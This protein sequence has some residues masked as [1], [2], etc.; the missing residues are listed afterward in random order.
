M[1]PQSLLAQDETTEGKEELKD[2]LKA[3]PISSVSSVVN[4]QVRTYEEL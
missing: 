4:R 3:S 1:K 2:F